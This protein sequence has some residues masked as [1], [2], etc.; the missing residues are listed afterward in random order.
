MR[1]AKAPISPGA[2]REIP[3][4]WDSEAITT[5]IDQMTGTGSMPPILMNPKFVNERDALRAAVEPALREDAKGH[6]SA[7]TRKRIHQA[8]ADFRTKFMNN[9]ADYQPGY[10]EALDYF[11][12]MASLNRML[13][14]P[15][16]KKF[17][18]LLE[19]GKEG[20]VGDLIAFMNAYNLRFGPAR[21]DRQIEIYTRLVPTLTAL[22]D[23]VNR[24][25]ARPSTLDR[26]GEGMRS[27]A[28]EALKGMPWDQLEAHSRTE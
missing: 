8:V 28:K 21:S 18:A 27:A 17:L 16:M 13:S 9:S 14:D 19:E 12:T 25:Q 10:Q 3:F 1:R 6:V 20:T 7:E 23:E 24:E 22:R 5:C 4:E 15:S 26:S 2:I 11:T